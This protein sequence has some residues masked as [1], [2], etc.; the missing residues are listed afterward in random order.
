MEQ[1]LFGLME[2]RAYKNQQHC[3]LTLDTKKLFDDY[4]DKITL[5]P[6]NTGSIFAV[7]P[8]RGPETFSTLEDF[9]YG[10]YASKRTADNIFVALTVDYGVYNVLNYVDTVHIMKERNIIRQL[11]PNYRD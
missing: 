6:L 10:E 3:V 7:G 9:P 1:R 11:Y 5:A 2:A 4:T 8:E